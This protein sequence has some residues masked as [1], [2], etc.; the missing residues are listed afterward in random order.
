MKIEEIKNYGKA[1]TQT[2]EENALEIGK[3]FKQEAPKIIRKHLGLFNTL[4]LLL[5]AGA[6]KKRLSR[7]DLTPVRQK[8]LN[9]EFFIKQRVEDAAMFSAM[10]KIAG[11]EKDL[12]INHEIMDKVAIP[13]LAFLLERVGQY[14]QVL[15]AKET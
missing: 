11:K 2:M 4:R 13:L 7:V 15:A 8:G 3:L 14:D 12:A 6:E 1:Y 10:T 9:S 5:L